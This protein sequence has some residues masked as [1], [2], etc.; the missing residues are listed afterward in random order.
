ML[1]EQDQLCLTAQTLLRILSYGAFNE[2]LGVG[3]SEIALDTDITSWGGTLVTP[4]HPAYD[5]EE[6]KKE[7]AEIGT[8][9]ETKEEEK[10]EVKMETA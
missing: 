1:E 3:E 8:T 9:E 10:K 5:K 7:S 4:G 2:I 6:H